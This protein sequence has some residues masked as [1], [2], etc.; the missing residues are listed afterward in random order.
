MRKRTTQTATHQNIVDD[1][2]KEIKC[3]QIDKKKQ[4]LYI[5]LSIF[6]LGTLNIISSFYPNIY[7][8]FVCKLCEVQDANY[9]LITDKENIKM[10][11]AKTENFYS[12][13]HILSKNIRGNKMNFKKEMSD[14]IYKGQDYFNKA[15]ENIVNFV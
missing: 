5:I 9:F 4:I 10:V 12:R 7:L 14:S 6:T 1:S 3:Y 11:G 8:S 13:N 15:E 2:I